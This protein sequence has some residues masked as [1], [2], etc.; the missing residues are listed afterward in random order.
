[1]T[2]IKRTRAIL[3]G[4]II[5]SAPA[6]AAEDKP[7]S[8]AVNTAP[9]AARVN[10]VVIP[11]SRVDVLVKQRVGQG[12]PES[13]ELRSNLRE[14]LVSSEIL[15]QEA[16]KRGFDKNHEVAAQMELA[17][18]AILVQAYL[19]DYLRRNPPSDEELK[20]EYDKIISQLGDKEYKAQHILVETEKEAKNIIAQLNKGAKFDKLASEKSQDKGSKAKGGELGWSTAANYVAPFAEALTNLQKGQYT[21]QPVKTEFGWHVI[22]L[23]DA[24]PTQPP[25]FDQVKNNLAQRQQ[26]QQ[27]EKLIAELR[28]NAKIE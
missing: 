18:Q 11:Q 10:G 1:M 26:Q 8:G 4:L 12:T 21:K 9:V 27:V 5:A 25:P 16:I 17:K 3:L 2:S 28:K 15:A 7:A 20:A 22:K 14:H 19:Q 24:R 6:C 13:P 23:E